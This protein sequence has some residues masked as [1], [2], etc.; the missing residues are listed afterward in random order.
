ML[1]LAAALALAGC[2]TD[3]V[4]AARVKMVQ[5]RYSKE[6]GVTSA[7]LH[8]SLKNESFDTTWWGT[9]TLDDAIT[10]EDQARLIARFF[11]IATQVGGLK[12]NFEWIIV[13][14][15]RRRS[16]SLSSPVDEARATGIL[17]TLDLLPEGSTGGYDGSSMLL[18]MQV[19]LPAMAVEAFVPAAIDLVT[20]AR[21]QSFPTEVTVT[22]GSLPDESMIY[23]ARDLTSSEK[24][25]LAALPAWLALLKTSWLVVPIDDSST[26]LIRIAT[27][28][29]ESSAVRELA[30][31]ARTA[32]FKQQIDAYLVGTYSPYLSI[33]RS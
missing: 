23:A 8:A 31:L 10:I 5:D 14:L 4:V 19:K 13:N 3:P 16:M 7:D 15:P 25:F 33:P 20:I 18:E 12:E 6:A 11:E 9:V 17:T 29:D 24:S 22:M 32:G 27:A 21:P 30:L 1:G 28:E 2:A 26:S